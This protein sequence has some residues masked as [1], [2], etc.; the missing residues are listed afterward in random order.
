VDDF[1]LHFAFGTSLLN[2]HQ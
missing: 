2:V 1:L